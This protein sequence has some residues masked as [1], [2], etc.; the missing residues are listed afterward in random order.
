MKIARLM[1]TDVKTCRDSDTL[2]AAVRL[3]WDCDIGSVPVVDHT[4]QI[5]GIVTDRDACMAAYTQAQ[6]LHVL[7]VTLAMSKHV[8]TCR[9]DDS[10]VSVAALMAKHKIRR[11]PVVDDANK[12]IGVISLS[13]LAIATTRGREVPPNEVAGTLAA[14]CEHRSAPSA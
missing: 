12:P 13:D 11:L 5:I 2:D 10:N 14:V 4:G 9:F 1:T 8:V 3:M 6:P 7:P